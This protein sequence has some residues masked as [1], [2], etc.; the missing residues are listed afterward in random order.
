[1]R[2]ATFVLRAF[3]IW[4]LVLVVTLFSPLIAVRLRASAAHETVRQ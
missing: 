2:R 1:M 3:G 4:L